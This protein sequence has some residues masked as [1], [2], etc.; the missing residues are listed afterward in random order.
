MGSRKL[1]VRVREGGYDASQGK[2]TPLRNQDCSLAGGEAMGWR[3]GAG[4]VEGSALLRSG[5]KRARQRK[6]SLSSKARAFLRTGV[7]REA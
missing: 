4:E 5:K 7:D 3:S 1:L 6:G 2:E